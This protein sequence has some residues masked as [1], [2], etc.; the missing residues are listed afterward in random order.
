MLRWSPL[1]QAVSFIFH[2]LSRTLETFLLRQD[3]TGGFLV[4]THISARRHECSF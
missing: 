2:P 3:F 1:E 4:H